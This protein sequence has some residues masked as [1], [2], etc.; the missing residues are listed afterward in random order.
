MLIATDGSA[1]NGVAG[2]GI[3]FETR[4][5]YHAK[6]PTR[7]VLEIT[8]D[9]IKLGK[10]IKPTNNRAEIYAVILAIL[11]A[12]KL[13]EEAEI[14]TDSQYVISYLKKYNSRGPIATNHD[15]VNCLYRALDLSE[16][17]VSVRWTEAHVSARETRTKET[18]LNKEADRISKYNYVV[19]EDVTEINLN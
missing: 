19:E 15:L 6:V 18:L 4:L 8:L 11:L 1:W 5:K 12:T 17:G 3:V 7:E 14:I 10:D 2:I 16:Y 13:K 9:G